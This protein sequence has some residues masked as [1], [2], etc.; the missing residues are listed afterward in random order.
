MQ[1]GRIVQHGTFR[2]GDNYILQLG[3]EV[4]ALVVLITEGFQCAFLR[5][6]HARQK[7]GVVLQNG[8]VYVRALVVDHF[9]EPVALGE[10]SQLDRHVLR[11]RLRGGDDQAAPGRVDAEI[12]EIGQRNNEV[13]Q[14]DLQRKGT[15][16]QIK[17][18][19]PQGQRGVR[20]RV[21][22]IY[23]HDLQKEVGDR[24][25]EKSGQRQAGKDG[26]LELAADLKTAVHHGQPKKT[27][28][29]HTHGGGRG[30][31][32]IQKLGIADGQKSKKR[33]EQPN[34]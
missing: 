5:V 2:G 24:V 23:V 29:K 6:G 18:L 25:R 1:K 34:I 27:Y 14:K 7:N 26:T 12:E 3:H 30:T 9:A 17:I 13:N 4:H 22:R 32:Q 10:R 11:Q 19:A 28:R 33:N 20:L 16:Q 15:H 31:A 8:L 21:L